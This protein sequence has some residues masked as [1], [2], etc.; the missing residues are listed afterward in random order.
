MADK[1]A[2]KKGHRPVFVEYV[3]EITD[4]S[5]DASFLFDEDLTKIALATI[6]NKKSELYEDVFFKSNS[7]WKLRYKH[8]IF[9]KLSTILLFSL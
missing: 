8:I 5:R 3:N 7:F 2:R 4:N 9:E 1:I 6:Q